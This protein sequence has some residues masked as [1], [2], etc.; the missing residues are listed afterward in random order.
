MDSKR[1]QVENGA[2][3]AGTSSQ[4]VLIKEREEL[5]KLERDFSWRIEKN[6]SEE[7]ELEEGLPNINFEMLGEEAEGDASL[8]DEGNDYIGLE[9]GM[10]M[11]ICF[12]MS[13]FVLVFALLLCYENH[14]IET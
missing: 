11:R 7:E 6:S 8:D 3:Q 1:K 9:E 13:H 4:R 5:L 2:G 12:A 14:E 10:G